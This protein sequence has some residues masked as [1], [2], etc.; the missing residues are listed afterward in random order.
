MINY[1]INYHNSK[2][3]VSDHGYYYHYYW[4]TVWIKNSLN[5]QKHLVLIIN[6]LDNLIKHNVYNF[7]C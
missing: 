1:D 4:P 2:N 5:N 7:N 6:L 3:W